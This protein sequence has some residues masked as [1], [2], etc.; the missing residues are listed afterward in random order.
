MR[1]AHG[2]QGGDSQVLCLGNDTVPGTSSGMEGD[3]KEPGAT[4][5]LFKLSS[6]TEL[7]K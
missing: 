7:Q 4:A 2:A 6:F 1:G 3:H 5:W